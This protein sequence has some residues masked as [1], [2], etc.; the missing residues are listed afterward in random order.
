MVGFLGGM[1]LFF[2]PL[3][4]LAA[5]HLTIEE[6]KFGVDRLAQ[7]LREEP[8]VKEPLD[9]KP[10]TQFASGIRFRSVVSPTTI[11]RFFRRST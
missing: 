10:L 8:S 1:L 5:L 6:S 4:K 2:G 7:I 9:P 3:K 11:A